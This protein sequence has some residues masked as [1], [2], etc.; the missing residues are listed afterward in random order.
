MMSII[1]RDLSNGGIPA[2]LGGTPEVA[3]DLCENRQVSLQIKANVQADINYFPATGI[4]SKEEDIKGWVYNKSMTQNLH[5]KRNRIETSIGG[6]NT[7]L[8]EGQV[9]ETWFSNKKSGLQIKSIEDVKVK[10]NVKIDTGEYSIFH[11]SKKLYTNE[12]SNVL[13]KGTNTILPA[14][15]LESLSVVLFKR[16]NEYT[17]IP[18]KEWKYSNSNESL[19]PTQF[20]LTE[21]E[22]ATFTLEVAADSYSK[23]IKTKVSN[24]EGNITAT[25]ENVECKLEF[26]G[27]GNN[28]SRTIYSEFFPIKKENLIVFY[29]VGN[30]YTAAKFLE[31]YTFD[32]LNDFNTVK[33][34]VDESRGIITTTG[35]TATPL[36][37][38][39]WS[40]GTKVIKTFEETKEFPESGFLQ[41]E[42]NG[43]TEYLEYKE[44]TKYGFANV[45]RGLFGSDVIDN[46]VNLSA[47]Y[48]PKGAAIPLDSKIYIS[49]TAVPRV[50]FEVNV[51]D[52]D[53]CF[54]D[55]QFNM[56]PQLFLRQNGILALSCTDKHLSYIELSI[57]KEEIEG[58]GVYGPLNIGYDSAVFTA[59][60]VDNKGNPVDELLTTFKS[61]ENHIEFEGDS[62]SIT[63]I[64]NNEGFARTVGFVNYQENKIKHAFNTMQVHERYFSVEVPE[65]LSADIKTHDIFVFE[66]MEAGDS[67]EERLVYQ[68]N[69]ER[70]K[71][72]PLQPISIV[73]DGNVTKFIFDID[74][75]LSIQEGRTK[76][77]YV[78][79]SKI[80][81]VY[82]EAEDPA[83]GRI[84]RSNVIKVKIDLPK[85]LKGA[86]INDSV[87]EAVGFGFKNSD[88]SAEYGT[89]VGGANF[90]TINPVENAGRFNF[91]IENDLQE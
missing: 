18:Y 65:Q 27:F 78:Y 3:P 55:Y 11:K 38:R 14:E 15:S 24:V 36:R 34:K 54:S 44:K 9:K 84:I 52:K 50:D 82:C 46:I 66:R 89:G 16:D 41:I 69:T 86:Y 91:I 20:V 33:F 88:G 31:D 71:Y 77:F 2:G 62:T 32:D 4:F 67:E 72:L 75:A 90:I 30:G 12:S 1:A 22:D 28:N 80:C 64:S 47:I 83:T 60:L 48:K 51:K 56:K 29:K 13:I 49:Y 23:N 21:N 39:E 40:A 79:Y 73:R 25:E 37:I 85:A 76:G 61:I 81:N 53:L 19:T 6:V 5:E 42:Q 87:L 35:R 26:K 7:N 10:R 17:N 57:S 63:N 68:Y 74:E 70:D 45:E 43:E 59:E 8:D 58:T